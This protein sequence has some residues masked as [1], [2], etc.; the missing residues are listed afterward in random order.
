MLRSL[1]LTEGPPHSLF[2]ILLLAGKLFGAICNIA[3]LVACLLIT[4]GLQR[5]PCL[6]QPF[7]GLLGLA[8]RLRIPL[9]ALLSTL[10]SRSRAAHVALRLFQLLDRLIELL[11][12]AAA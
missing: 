1:A 4:Q 9:L 3:N 11:L 5:L 8:L 10:T 7:S 6:L 12:L 2:E